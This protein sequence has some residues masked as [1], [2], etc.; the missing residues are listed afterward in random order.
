MSSNPVQPLAADDGEVIFDRVLAFV[1][2]ALVG[3]ILAAQFL[4]MAA[5]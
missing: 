2:S 4:R 3:V 1:A 5:A